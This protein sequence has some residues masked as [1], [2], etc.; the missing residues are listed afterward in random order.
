MGTAPRFKLPAIPFGQVLWTTK[1]SQVLSILT[2]FLDG[3]PTQIRRVYQHSGA[4][5]GPGSTFLNL[6][7]LNPATY[8]GHQVFVKDA[9]GTNFGTAVTKLAMSDG[10]NWIWV[11]NGLTLDS[12]D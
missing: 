6:V 2:Q 7:D 1:L 4:N 11:G 12:I 10:T 5:P 9:D 8:E 3:Q